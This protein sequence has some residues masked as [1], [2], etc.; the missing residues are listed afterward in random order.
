MRRASGIHDDGRP[1]C[2]PPRA[3]SRL[4]LLSRRQMHVLDDPA[5]SEEMLIPCHGRTDGH[6]RRFIAVCLPPSLGAGQGDAPGG[7]GHRAGQPPVVPPR[8]TARARDR[9]AG[10]TPGR[11]RGATGDRSLQLRGIAAVVVPDR[12]AELK[13]RLEGTNE[14]R[15]AYFHRGVARLAGFTRRLDNRQPSRLYVNLDNPAVRLLAAVGE[16]RD[17]APMWR[18]CCCLAQSDHRRTGR[19]PARDLAE[20]G[21]GRTRRFEVT[22]WGNK[23]KFATRL[24][25]TEAYGYLE[26]G[27]EAPRRPA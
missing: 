23:K 24:M 16:E 20:P 9:L 22:C 17:E 25:E 15:Q 4:Q 3:T 13:R 11:L 18:C 27:G 6:S 2:L 14:G 19:G 12:D 26:L 5:A 7:A 1:A 8:P 10:R 21:P